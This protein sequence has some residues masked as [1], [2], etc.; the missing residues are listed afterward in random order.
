MIGKG[1][2]TFHC[3][4]REVRT[5]ARLPPCEQGSPSHVPPRSMT[6]LPDQATPLAKLLREQ[7]LGQ[8][9]RG[10]ST[11]LRPREATRPAG[12]PGTPFKTITIERSVTAS[13][14]P[15]RHLQALAPVS[16]YQTAAWTQAWLDTEGRAS[17]LQPLICIARDERDQ[18]VALLPL[19]LR[20]AGL[21]TVAGFLGG[22]HS[23]YNFGLFD[24][25]VAW[26]ADD[27][28]GLL[29][30]IAA[31]APVALDVLALTNQPHAWG[32]WNNPLALLPWQASPSRAHRAVLLPDGD[33]FLKLH[34][35][36]AALKKMRSKASQLAALGPVSH[37]VAKYP[38]EI[39]A[40]LD[41]H[42]AQKSAKLAS[43]GAAHRQDLAA[44]R[45]LFERAATAGPD[46][47]PPL[48]L[49][50]LLC[51]DRI[52]ATFGGLAHAGRFSGLLISH[53]ADPVFARLSPGE[54]LLAAVI[55]AKCR[56]RFESFDL[57]I[58]EARYKEGFCPIADPLFDS[59]VPMTLR[60]R[61][62]VAQE[63]LRLRLKG[64][65]KQSS[66]AWPLINRTRRRLA[67][68]RLPR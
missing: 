4:A 1:A 50:A 43:I 48:E 39:V 15:W 42:M 68:R 57:G 29:Q 37:L 31:A 16:P 10:W 64:R 56:D 66:W 17:P 8:P 53:D 61:L 59:L 7:G 22:R 3:Y 18:P 13:R 9:G 26:S 67:A 20:R 45:Q 27:V 51:G 49:H 23:N 36:S 38:G 21:V 11:A 58:G 52:V 46:G 25:S 34:Q 2:L 12:D 40:V 60:G 24:P 30:A 41:A 6:V 32:A 54:V 28:Q 65:I 35:S 55:K 47:E 5:A 44:T 19:G 14:E 63:A 33:A 62:F